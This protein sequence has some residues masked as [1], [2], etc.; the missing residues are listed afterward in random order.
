MKIAVLANCQAPGFAE[1]IQSLWR[2]SNVTAYHG[3]LLAKL[4]PLETF[5]LIF[6]H[7]LYRDRYSKGTAAAGRFKVFPPVI[8]TGFHPDATYIFHDK[9]AI[10]APTSDYHSA[11]VAAAFVRG[12]PPDEVP[13]LFNP[14]LFQALG[15]LAEFGRAKTFLLQEAGKM[16]FDL[17]GPFESWMMREDAFMHTINHP[18]IQVLGD[19]ARLA[20]QKE[21]VVPVVCEDMPAD[22]LARASSWP[23]YDFVADRLGVSGRPEFSFDIP[24]GGHLPRRAPISLLEFTRQSYALYE[25][26]PRELIA[27]AKAVAK[28]LKVI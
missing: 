20:I 16:D 15:Y 5:D 10:R 28:A 22:V 1:C 11:I 18:T 3:S 7:P 14:Q 6:A 13:S 8:F 9:K 24:P 25:A 27:E 12:M 17:A 23:I 26:L 4:P 2:G 21:N 19:I